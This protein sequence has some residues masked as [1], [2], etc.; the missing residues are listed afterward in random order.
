MGAVGVVIAD[1]ACILAGDSMPVSAIAMG[2]PRT[3]GAAFAPVC[4]KTKCL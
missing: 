2:A 4:N 1:D 3:S